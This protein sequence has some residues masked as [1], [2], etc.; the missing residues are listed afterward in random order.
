MAFS[1]ANRAPVYT[2][3]YYYYY[4]RIILHYNIYGI[5]FLCHSVAKMY[6]ARLVAGKHGLVAK[7]GGKDCCRLCQVTPA[8]NVL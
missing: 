2:D 7:P 6:N 1:N 8:G 3:Y 4:R 5:G